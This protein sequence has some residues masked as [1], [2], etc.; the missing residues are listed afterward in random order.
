VYTRGRGEDGEWGKGEKEGEGGEYRVLHAIKALIRGRA[1]YK[2]QQ[3][4]PFR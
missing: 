4:I 3:M 2:E 1:L